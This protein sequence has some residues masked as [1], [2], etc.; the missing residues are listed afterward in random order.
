MYIGN[1]LSCFQLLGQFNSPLGD[2]LLAFLHPPHLPVFVSI[3]MRDIAVKLLCSPCC[4]WLS[5][6]T[7]LNLR[8]RCW[9]GQLL[10]PSSKGQGLTPPEAARLKPQKPR[11]CLVTC[12]H[13]PYSRGGEGRRGKVRQCSHFMEIDVPILKGRRACRV[14]KLC[15]EL[16]NSS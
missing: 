1:Q 9:D 5:G 4:C 6:L 10:P 7:V 14:S 8:V 12:T 13:M 11:Q 3:Y 2:L 16:L 15:N